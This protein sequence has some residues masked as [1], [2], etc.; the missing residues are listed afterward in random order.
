MKK[1]FLLS[2]TG[3]I[4]L[5]VCTIAIVTSL[6]PK[7]YVDSLPIISIYNDTSAVVDCEGNLWMW[8]FGGGYKVD[9]K[10]GIYSYSGK[11]A[12][13]QFVANDV[14]NVCVGRRSV[15]VIK[16]DG[17]LWASGDIYW[18]NILNT[19]TLVKI[20]DDVKSVSSNSGTFAVIKEDGTLW[21]WGANNRGNL[22]NGSKAK[23]VMV[24]T[25]NPWHGIDDT[26]TKIMDNVKYV[27]MGHYNG[28]AIKEDGTLWTWG[29]NRKYMLG[30]DSSKDSYEPIKIMNDVDSVAVGLYCMGA[31][32]R[33]GSLWMWGENL[34]YGML[35]NDSTKAAKT[36]LKVMTNVKSVCIGDITT[37]AMKKDGS[38][39]VWGNNNGQFANDSIDG[40]KKPVKIM[41]NIFK[42]NTSDRVVSVVKED[43]SVWSWGEIYYSDNIINGKFR[44]V[45]HPKKVM[46]N[47]F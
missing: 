10:L 11:P 32:K 43:G 24:P 19:D 39:W 20:M 45:Y 42:F 6:I 31:V 37:M 5:F 7:G 9:G 15:L 3:V 35:G 1:T 30:N 33:D 22:G 2:I 47:V 25:N 13:P 34:S 46:D 26:P 40:S 27:C 12:T 18:N 8:G 4:I 28:A 23:S 21:T 17:S 16:N 29:D 44:D 41:D 38:L 36:P 14:K